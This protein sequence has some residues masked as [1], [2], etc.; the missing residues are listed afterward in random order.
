MEVENEE[1]KEE[2]EEEE[3]PLDEDQK[4]LFLKDAEISPELEAQYQEIKAREDELLTKRAKEVMQE[5]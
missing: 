4:A 3:G 5:E 2:Y 1:G